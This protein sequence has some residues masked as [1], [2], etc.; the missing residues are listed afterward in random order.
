MVPGDSFTLGNECVIRFQPLVAPVLHEINAYVHYFFVPYRLLWEDWEDFITGG[1]DGEAAPVLPRWHPTAQ[2]AAVGTLWDYL[3]FPTG[4]IPNGALP[5]DFPRRA[6]NLIY[7][8]FYRDENLQTEVDL[9]NPDI[10]KRAW[11]KDYFTSSYSCTAHYF[12][13]ESRPFFTYL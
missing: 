4:V 2:E 11:S 7:N 5:L 9:D 1:V 8:E 12:S 6:Y 10:L 3:G 13:S